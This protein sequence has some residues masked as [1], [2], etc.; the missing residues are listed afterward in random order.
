[1]SWLLDTHTLLWLLENEQR[2][3]STLQGTRVTVPNCSK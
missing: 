3:G 2:L 1:M